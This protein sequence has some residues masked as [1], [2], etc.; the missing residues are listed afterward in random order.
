MTD[1]ELLE[2]A[3]KAARLSIEFVPAAARNKGSSLTKFEVTSWSGPFIAGTDGEKPWNPST[4]DGDALR[5]RRN[6]EGPH[7][8]QAKQQQ[9]EANQ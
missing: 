7:D 8:L 6:H 2:L 4:D 9:R 5:Q 3:A 1:R